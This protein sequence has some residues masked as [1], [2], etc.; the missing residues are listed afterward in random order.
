MMDGFLD[1]FF[2]RPTWTAV[3]NG[4]MKTDILGII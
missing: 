2:D 3:K 4:I 1:G